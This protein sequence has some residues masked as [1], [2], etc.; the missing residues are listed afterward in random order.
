MITSV[1]AILIFFS[2]LFETLG[3]NFRRIGKMCNKSSLGYSLHVQFATVSRLGI[4]IGFPLIGY[5]IDQSSDIENILLVPV[6]CYFLISTFLF[7][8]AIYV[9]RLDN[10][11]KQFFLLQLKISNIDRVDFDEN[12]AIPSNSFSKKRI[13]ILGAISF[14]F[15]SS[16]IFFVSILSFTFSD[17]KATILLSSPA[18]TAIGTLIS[19]IFF[20]PFIS[21]QI[22][23]IDEP[24]NVIKYI[25]FSRA[26]SSL[27]LFVFFLMFYLY[28]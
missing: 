17:L 13:L 21:R 14:L 4:F 5:L 25:Y 11:F 22:D 10:L 20:D 16:G 8:S 23:D 1:A 12:L 15:A 24:V 3:F 7:I 19:V 2:L 18:I 9:H 28:V 27:I 26:L 6:I